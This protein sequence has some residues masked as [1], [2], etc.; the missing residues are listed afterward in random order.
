[1]QTSNHRS[2]IFSRRGFLASVAGGAATAILAACGGS[3][4]TNTPATSGGATTGTTTASGASAVAGTR[5]T[6]SATTAATTSTGAGAASTAAIGSTTANVSATTSVASTT[7]GIAGTPA[8]TAATSASAV[9]GTTTGTTTSAGSQTFTIDNPPAVANATAAKQFSSQKLTYYGDSVGIGAQLDQALAKRFTQDTGIQVKV[10]PKPQAGTDA[11]QA[12]LRFFQAQSADLDVLM[13]DVIWPGAFAPHL[14][15]LSSKLGAEAKQHYPNIIQNDTVN[16]KL[17]ALPWFADVGIL[18]YRTD[19]LKKYGY[20]APPQTWDELQQQATK[21]MNGEKASNPNFTGFVFQG[22]AYEGLT[23]DALEW[24]ASTGG[25]QIIENNKVT[26]NNPQATTT[27]NM[28]KG[29]VGTIAPRGVTTFQEDDARNVFQ[30]GNAAFMRNWP[31]AYAAAKQGSPIQNTFDAGALPAA[32]GQ[33][34][35]GT[36]GGWQLGVSKYSKNQDAGVEFV[37][38]MAGPDVQAWRAVVGTFL[39]T[40][41]SVAAMPAVVQAQPFLK[42]IGD[43]QRVT[44]PSTVL[45]DQY[46]QG[47]TIFFQGVNQILNG[48]DAS[49]VLPG[50][51]QQLQR[52]LG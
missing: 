2:L 24:L 14:L 44:R 1:M 18:Y 37:R 43:V 31:Y 48:Q 12:F 32:S 42:N 29:W 26:V 46:N 51:A 16:G 3:K 40:I 34:H 20:S 4:A 5:A 17:V 39:P 10:V 35:V 52:L 19:L 22:S 21:I 11:Y 9:T 38:Y 8:A 23:C 36:V 30:G 28:V 13:L 45:A 25:G 49:G 7:A 27:L 33:P 15:D 41:Q 6:G 50:V 47:S